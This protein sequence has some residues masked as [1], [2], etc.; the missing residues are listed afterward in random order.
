MTKNILNDIKTALCFPHF[1]L[2]VKYQFVNVNNNII[3]GG[4]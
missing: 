3:G 4:F 2:L 1:I